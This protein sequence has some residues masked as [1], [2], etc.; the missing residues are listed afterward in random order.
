MG[1]QEEHIVK[2]VCNTMKTEQHFILKKS[3]L[4][5]K[6]QLVLQH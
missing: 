2:K 5:N 3:K 1:V 6:E 4:T